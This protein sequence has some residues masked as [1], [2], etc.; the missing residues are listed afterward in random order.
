MKICFTCKEEKDASEYY[1]HKRSSDGLTYN[2]K[3]CHCEKVYKSYRKNNPK[4]LNKK[5]ITED[6]NYVKNYREKNKAKLSIKQKQYYLNNKD[7]LLYKSRIYYIN[8]KQKINKQNDIR[9][10]KKASECNITRCK[11]RISNLIRVSVKSK[12]YTKRSRTFEILGCEYV[13]F[14]QYI[15]GQFKLGMTWENIHLD[16]IKPINSAKTEQEVLELNHYTNFQPL[17]AIDNLKKSNKLIT[18]QLRIL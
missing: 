13:F 4:N 16:H 6:P 1:K 15:E 5:N 9:K 12:G 14:K 8:N 18:K 2:C 10:R 11:I 7:N 17:L 3:K